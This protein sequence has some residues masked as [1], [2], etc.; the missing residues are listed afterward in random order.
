MTNPNKNMGL[1][2]SRVVVMGALHS[3][4]QSDISSC[5]TGAHGTATQNKTLLRSTSDEELEIIS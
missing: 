5:W 4:E 2:A 1:S 3:L